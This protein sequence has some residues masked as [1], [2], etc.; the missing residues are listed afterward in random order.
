MGDETGV[1]GGGGAT[2][3]ARA[4]AELTRGA[5]AGA[6]PV[7]TGISVSQIGQFTLLTDEGGAKA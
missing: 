3:R 5:D 2:G 4:M 7:F 6:E 1:R